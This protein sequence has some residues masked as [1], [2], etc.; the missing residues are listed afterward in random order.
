VLPAVYIPEAEIVPP[1]AVQV[2]LVFDV[3]VTAAE[4]CCFAP[5]C[6]EASSGSTEI[7]TM[8][9]PGF[10]GDP[11]VPLQLVMLSDKTK[12]QTSVKIWRQFLLCPWMVET[13]VETPVETEFE[14][15]ERAEVVIRS[16]S[17]DL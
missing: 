7:P 17:P 8:P 1:V 9:V 2:T 5:S 6:I 12:K 15:S 11:V 10:E 13:T 16:S 14:A 4:N 3:P